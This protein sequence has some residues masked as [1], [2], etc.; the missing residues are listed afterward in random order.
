MIKNLQKIS[1]L[2]A[3]GLV[4]GSSAANAQVFYEPFAGTGTVGGADATTQGASSN[5][6]TAHSPNSP[7][8]TG[9]IS[10]V[11][12]SL[13]YAGLAASTGNKV[14]L[15]GTN[16]TVSRDINAD[17]STSLPAGT[18]TAYFSALVNVE[19]ATQL[20]ADGD[21]F[22]HFGNDAGT[23][24]TT[25]FARLFIK[26]SGAGYKL[27]ILN[28]SG[29]TPA[30][31]ATDNAT[32]LA[33]GTTYLVVVKYEIKTGNDM[34]SLWVNPALGDTEP[35]GGVTNEAGT[36][37]GPSRFQSI[38]LRNSSGTPKA[39][40]DEIRV[41]TTF[42]A[43][44]PGTTTTGI[45]DF[46]EG[47]LGLFPNP[48]TGAVKLQL[49]ASFS[50][51]NKVRLTVYNVNGDLLLKSTGSEKVL[52]EQ[53]AAKMGAAAAGMYLVKINDGAQAYQTRIVKN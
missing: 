9:A 23:P 17:I 5:G 22:M 8:T 30:P 46:S 40:I 4:L 28:T 47:N 26:S 10:I 42:A 31:V 44:T 20:S 39:Y 1:F 2:L 33:F 43:V 45:K 6:W 34:A 3:A 15:P 50:G 19:D 25:L 41:G 53:L 13:T 35:T 7:T 52:N 29:G 12:G 27:G 48:T 18:T 36:S 11:E 37:S 24:N 38:S 51:K 49:P 21:Y 32:E 14:L 16:S